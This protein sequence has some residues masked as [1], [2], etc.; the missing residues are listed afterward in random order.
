MCCFLR[1]V[2]AGRAWSRMPRDGLPLNVKRV[3]KNAWE[4]KA[5]GAKN[6]LVQVGGLQWPKPG[7]K[8]SSIGVC[9]WHRMCRWTEEEN[10]EPAFPT[11]K[12]NGTGQQ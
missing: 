1:L 12:A 5:S 3:P 10:P 7:I 4:G 8:T 9:W 6:L 11:A 2:I